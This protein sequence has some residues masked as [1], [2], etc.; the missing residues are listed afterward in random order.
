[1]V[2]AAN[3]IGRQGFEVQFERVT[4]AK[5]DR[6]NALPRL[7]GGGSCFKKPVSCRGIR[8]GHF[9]ALSTGR[10]SPIENKRADAMLN[11]VWRLPKDGPRQVESGRCHATAAIFCSAASIRNSP[12]MSLGR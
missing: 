11:I 9:D 3:V 8:A 10:T 4:E 6:V 12:E 7:V 1:R 5:E 2:N